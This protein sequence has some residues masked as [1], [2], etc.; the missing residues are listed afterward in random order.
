M[1]D[2]IIFSGEFKEYLG[3][4]NKFFTT[5]VARNV[6]LKPKKAYVGF[7]DV[8]LLGQHVNG[9]GLAI[10]QEQVEAIK[11]IQKPTDVKQLNK[12]LSITRYL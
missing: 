8:R 6:T 11:N 12:F 7:L 1:D 2:Y 10:L 9:L 5:L 4:L 3:H